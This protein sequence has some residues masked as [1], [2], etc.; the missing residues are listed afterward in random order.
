MFARVVDIHLMKRCYSNNNNNNRERERVS[1]GKMHQQQYL[2]CNRLPADFACRL[3]RQ[4]EK[5]SK[6]KT[7]E[8]SLSVCASKLK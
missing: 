6:E 1:A 5:K 4:T 3:C 2:N 7:D 8:V